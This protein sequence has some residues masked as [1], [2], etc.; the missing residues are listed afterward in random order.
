MRL[1]IFAS[2]C[3]LVTACAQGPVG[4]PNVPEPAKPVE[5][6]RYLGQWYEIA[7]YENRFEIGCAAASARYAALPDG[8]I[9][10]TNR[11]HKGSVTGPQDEAVGTAYVVEGSNNAKLR[12]SFFWPFYG[13]YWVLDHAPDYRWSIVGEPSGRYLWILAREPKL[14]A[15]EITMLRNRVA[16]LG[17]DLK[18]LHMT[19]Q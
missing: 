15:R 6:T 8:K 3:L 10:V 12:V 19:V 5:L 14:K 13:D 7:R 11:C 18:L 16:E 2:I 17:Y 1:F 9:Q 4:N